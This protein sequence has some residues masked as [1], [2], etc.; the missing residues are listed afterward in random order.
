MG[1][2]YLWLTGA[3]VGLFLVGGAGG[4]LGQV[5]SE[6]TWDSLRRAD[7]LRSRGKLTEAAGL[8]E[9]LVR[10][11]S[12]SHYEQAM[13]RHLFAHV[14]LAA[15][16]YVGAVEQ[17]EGCL[18]A[19]ALPDAVE[20][21]IRYDVAQ[22]LVHV[23]RPR[24]AVTH[25]EQ[26][27]RSAVDPPSSAYLLLTSA[28]MASGDPAAAAVTLQR[29]IDTASTVQPHWLQ[30]LAGL[31]YETGNLR[32]AIEAVLELVAV[33]PGEQAHWERLASLY[34]AVG[35]E[36]RALAVGE[37][38]LVGGV[39][40][41][42]SRILR[43]ARHMLHA[44]LPH[45]A[46]R[47]LEGAVRDGTVAPDAA[48]T[49]LLADAC[50]DAREIERGVRWLVRAAEAGG[51]AAY[52]RLGRTL[53]RLERWAEASDAL[54]RALEE[55]DGVDVGATTLLVGLCRLEQGRRQDALRA[56]AAA[57]GHAEVRQTAEQ[58]YEAVA[59]EDGRS[60]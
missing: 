17:L 14:L 30:L 24:D 16:D 32:G 45:R 51:G 19:H 34:M 28:H 15:D 13:A 55:P 8:L 43:T 33:Q 44:G 26:W 50:L 12:G 5:L 56:F 59:T 40:T 29:A 11:T 53:C 38:A 23:G 6:R 18:A 39:P 37:A 2:N 25:L 4:L 49:A 52:V 41:D 1:S 35:D 54:E 22:L 21:H 42:G 48:T 9:R 27:F 36:A 46:V 58:W 47:L 57:R 31:L 3:L 10:S 60:D 7:D 20:R